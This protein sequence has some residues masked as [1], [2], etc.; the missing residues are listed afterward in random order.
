MKHRSRNG[1]WL[2]PAVLLIAGFDVLPTLA[3]TYTPSAGI[4]L[5]KRF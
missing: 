2:I 4:S 5:L 3:T 1:L